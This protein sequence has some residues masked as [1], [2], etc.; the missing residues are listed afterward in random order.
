MKKHITF[1][2]AC[3]T[4][5]SACVMAEDWTQQGGP[6]HDFVL[7]GCELNMDWTEENVPVKWRA[8]VG[9]GSSPVVVKDGRVYTFGAY[10]PDTAIE[11][12]DDPARVPVESSKEQISLKNYDVTHKEAAEL[13]P[14]VGIEGFAPRHKLNNPETREKTL[15]EKRFLRTW[16][17]VQCLDAESGKRIWATLVNDHLLLSDNHQQWPRSSPLIVGDGLFIHDSNGQLFRLNARTGEIQWHVNLAEHGMQT[18]HDKEPNSCSPLYYEGKIIVQYNNRGMVVGAFDAETG[19]ETWRYTSGFDS[20][21]SHFSRLGFSEINGEP[22]VLVPDGWATTG[23]NPANGEIRWQLDVYTESADW[24]RKAYEEVKTARLAEGL[25]DPGTRQLTKGY[26]CYTSYAPVVWK[27]YVIDYRDYAHSDFISS[28]Y[29]LKLNEP[30][31]DIVWQTNRYV[32][33]AYPAKSNMIA[34]DGKLYFFEFS[35]HSYIPRVKESRL[36]RP[37]GVKQFLCIDIPTGKV[38]WSSDAFRKTPSKEDD[39]K[40]QPNGYKFI[41]SGDQIIA[42][43]DDGLW[44]GQITE[45]GAEAKAALLTGSGGNW[46]IPNLPAEPVLVDQTLFYRQTMPHE[47]AGILSKIGGQGNLVCLDLKP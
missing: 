24:V 26:A 25:P 23:L 30:K 15:A 34:R 31:P 37:E 44:L 39:F 2:I 7:P 22:T 17:Y 4:I 46:G 40:D 41:F 33:E 35:Y 13:Y 42:N 21:R 36:G 3:I 6:N 27:D 12:L 20:F 10:L 18:F 1:F 45:S 16:A 11:Q 47:G 28:T 9:F 29:C 19:E 43:G 32:P 14:Q 38:L 5:L 8:N